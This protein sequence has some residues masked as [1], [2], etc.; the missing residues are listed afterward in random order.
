MILAM[1]QGESGVAFDSNVIDVE[2]GHGLFVE[3][4]AEFRR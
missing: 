4:E 1:F 2:I 3:V